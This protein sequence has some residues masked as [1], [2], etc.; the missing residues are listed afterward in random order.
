MSVLVSWP[1]LQK[2]DIIIRKN[3]TEFNRGAYCRQPAGG[4]RFRRTDLDVTGA[5]RLELLVGDGGKGIASD[6]ADWAK[7]AQLPQNAPSRARFVDLPARNR[8]K[9]ADE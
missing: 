1:P 9:R 8:R 7:H 5:L 4:S 2:P 6:H 3:P